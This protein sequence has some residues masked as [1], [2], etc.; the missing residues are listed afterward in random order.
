MDTERTTCKAEGK[1]QGDESA[2]QGRP[3]IASK[4]PEA[5]EAWSAAF[6]GDLR[7]NS[8]ADTLVS[9]F[10]PPELGEN[11]FCCLS[12]PVCGSLLQQPWYVT[13]PAWESNSAHRLQEWRVSGLGEDG[14]EPTSCP[15]SKA[16]TTVVALDPLLLTVSMSGGLKC[17]KLGRPHGHVTWAIAQ[18]L[19]L[20]RVPLLSL[21]SLL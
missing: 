19:I 18:E 14:P 13:S 20:R 6:P 12:H 2:S 15:G 5:R 1:D 4:L 3:E 16:I 7:S 10:W 8:P 9:D 11:K 21:V 17:P